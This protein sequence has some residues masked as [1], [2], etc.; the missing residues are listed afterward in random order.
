VK[1]LRFLILTT[2]WIVAAFQLP[3]ASAQSLEK[4]LIT[5]TSDSV[6]ITPLLYGI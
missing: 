5:H 1:I 2:G 4:V 3:Q 6:S